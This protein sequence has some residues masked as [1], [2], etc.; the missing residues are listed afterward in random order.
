MVCNGVIGDH[1]LI[2][3]YV[4]PQHQ[5]GD[6]YENYLQNELP[7]LILF[8]RVSEKFL[9]KHDLRYSTSTTEHHLILAAS[10][11]IISIGNSLNRRIG[12]GG[13]LNWPPRPSNLN[14][15]ITVCGVTRKPWRTDARWTRDKN[16]FYEF[17]ML[18]DA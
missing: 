5:P 7:A 2:G 15:N 13:A 16:C 17:S 1:Q 18:Q 8:Y 11:G 10:S 12:R 9:H 4:I 14:S 3:P 6:M